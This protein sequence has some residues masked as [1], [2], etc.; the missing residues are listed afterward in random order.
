MVASVCLIPVIGS[1]ART[2][3]CLSSFQLL[4]GE[5]VQPIGEMRES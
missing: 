5:R 2:H 1:Q 4:C 3:A